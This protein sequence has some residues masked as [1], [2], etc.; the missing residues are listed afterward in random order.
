[1][2]I[3]SRPVFYKSSVNRTSMNHQLDIQ[4][5]R[6]IV[7]RKGWRG[8]KKSERNSVKKKGECLS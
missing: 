7:E 2:N 8:W 4:G 1:M 5:L 3:E 6:L